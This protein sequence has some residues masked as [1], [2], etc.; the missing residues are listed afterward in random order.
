MAE[1]RHPRWR[2]PGP[3]TRCHDEL[4]LP[5]DRVPALTNFPP[6]L[7]PHPARDDMSLVPRPRW[8]VSSNLAR[9]DFMDRR[10]PSTGALAAAAAVVIVS[11]IALALLPLI[12]RSASERYRSGTE[13][14]V[15]PARAALNTL[16]YR[17][18]LQITAL[19]RTAVTEDE[20]Q[21]DRYLRELEPQEQAMNALA[22]HA[23][24]LG[25]D[26]SA[27]LRDLERQLEDWRSSVQRSVDL[28]QLAFD[29]DY[30][31][32]IEAI[33]R[34]DEALTSDQASR[35]QQVRF[36][37]Q[38]QMWTTV[39]LVLL[40]AIASSLVL[41]ILQRLRSLAAMLSRESQARQIALEQEQKLVR[42]R[43][44]ILSVVA[45]DLRSPLT[46]IG[47]STQL[48][49]GSAEKDQAEHVETILA[50]TRRMQRLIQDLL[51]VTKL[52]SSRLTIQQDQV[53]PIAIAR[54]VV[55]EQRPIAREREITLETSIPDLTPKVCGDADRLA[56]ALT[57]LIGN[58]LKFTPAGGT[59]RVCVES[60]TSHVRFEVSDSGPGISPQDL[61]HLFEPFWQAKKT[62]HLGAGLGLKITRGIADAHGGSIEANNAPEG[63]ARFVLTVPVVK[64]ERA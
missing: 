51:D 21:L 63:G 5:A 15:E 3:F 18:G 29:E 50:T 34:V 22:V 41:W 60:D 26:V 52:E 1:S 64:D 2:K 47:L 35:R 39:G 19:T 32:V 54:E 40:A 11:L 27:P 8:P 57:N 12:T 10:Q 44:E 36:V 37:Q 24:A 20:L 43:D 42:M 48:I 13:E 6:P 49:P 4:I 53:D 58:A 59:V 61:P 23:R 31:P 62:A 45:H 17:L 14:H 46:T 55:S 38:I 56:Q 30:A 16:N 28:Q 25:P 9:S 7:I 33:H